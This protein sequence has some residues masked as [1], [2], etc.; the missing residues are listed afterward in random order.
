MMIAKLKKLEAAEGSGGAT[1]AYAFEDGAPAAT[2]AATARAY[3]DRARR[4]MQMLSVPR[5]GWLSG[6]GRRL[7]FG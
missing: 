5:D 1:A 4:E 3:K 7:V 2:D 6:P